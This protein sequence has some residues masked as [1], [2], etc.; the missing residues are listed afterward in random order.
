MNND[1]VI[2]RILAMNTI[3]VVGLSPKVERPSNDVARY[4]LGHGYRLIPVN[5]GHAEI[6]GLRAYPSLQDIPE[7]VEVVDV[8]RRQEYTPA[9]AQ[10]AAAVGAKALWLQLGIVNAEA[11]SIAEQAGLLAVQDLCIKIEHQLRGH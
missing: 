3:A 5:P 10:A 9:V 6:L 4:L 11:I 7:P 8:F 1:Q 2:E